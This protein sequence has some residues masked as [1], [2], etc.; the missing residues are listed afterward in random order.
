MERDPE[1][2]A[3]TRAWLHRAEEDLRAAEVD[4]EAQPP[5]LSD[6]AFHCQQATEKAL[7]AFLTWND[8]P[9]R[10]THDLTELGRQCIVL[11]TSTTAVFQRAAHLTAYAWAFRYPGEFESPTPEDVNQALTLAREVYSVVTSRLP[12]EAQP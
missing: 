5:L 12:G 9:F 11:D 7:K 3:D 1:R 10:K 2:S 8:V 4:I 6:A